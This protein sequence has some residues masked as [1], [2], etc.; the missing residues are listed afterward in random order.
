MKLTLTEGETH[1]SVDVGLKPSTN[2]T[3]NHKFYPGNVYK[4]DTGGH[5][6]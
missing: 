6:I 4:S 1:P 3:F 5:A 2:V